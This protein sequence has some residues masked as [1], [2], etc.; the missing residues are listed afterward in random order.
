MKYT[1]S[2]LCIIKNEE[3][4]E[5][6]IIYH[7]MLGIQHFYIFDNEST[8]PVS[9]RLN[10]YYYHKCCTIIPYPGKVKQIDSY[11]F[12]LQK[13][14]N[15]TD[16]VLIVDGDEFVLPKKHEN[17]LDF[18]N[19]FNDY[20]A[21]AVNWINFGSCYHHFKQPGYL[22]ENFKYCEKV[23]DGHVKSFSRPC[24]IKK[25]YNPHFVI[26]KDETKFKGYVDPLKKKLIF[27]NKNHYSDSQDSIGVIQVNHY[28][29]KSHQELEQKINRGRA[30]MGS[31]RE[32]PHNYH[33]LYHFRED[34]LIIKKFLPN[35]KRT[36]EAICTHPAMYKI[37]NKD[38]EKY[39]G[40]NLD[41]YTRHLIDN[42]IKEK[43]PY[44]IDHLIPDFNMEYYRLNYPDLDNLTCMQLIDH[45]VNYGKK[46]GRVYSRLINK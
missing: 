1:L 5:E 31:K 45:Y 8:V 16:W 2:L 34:K 28:W 13:Y 37:L 21:I 20:S 38:L 14:G 19:D 39:L 23:P 32:M 40:D 44:K 15:E 12:W 35:L 10:H 9:D 41:N 18:I 29:G 36:F 33:D 43:R 4:L 3:Y 22:I 7:R 27:D 25:I 30:M 26:L 42:G 24:D 6:F 11:N 17:L 46:E